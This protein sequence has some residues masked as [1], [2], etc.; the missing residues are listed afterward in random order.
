MG[1]GGVRVPSGQR[2]VDIK[3]DVGLLYVST[4]VSMGAN[5]KMPLSRCLACSI[6]SEPCALSSIVVGD[7]GEIAVMKWCSVESREEP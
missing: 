3:D 5:L 4:D 1:E 2:V 6:L 7:G